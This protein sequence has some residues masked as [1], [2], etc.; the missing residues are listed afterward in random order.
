[1]ALDY[2]KFLKSQRDKYNDK[3][4]IVMRT[5]FSKPRTSVG[6]K[7]F[8][9]DPYLNN[10]SIESGLTLARE[11]LI[12]ILEIGVPCSMEHVSQSFQHFDDVLCW[13]AGAR[14][15]ESQIHRELASGISTP[16]D[17]KI[18]LKEILMEAIN[19]IQSANNQHCF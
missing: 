10:T 8:V 15:S 13:A 19:A 16:W 11:L 18:I 14:T 5:Y 12:K 2:A 4:E 17:L 6:W 7:G 1:M 9:Y 3:I